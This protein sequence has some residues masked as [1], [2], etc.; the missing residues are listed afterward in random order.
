MR[1]EEGGTE[2]EGEVRER[3]GW[4]QGCLA[5]AADSSDGLAAQPGVVISN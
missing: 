3:R 5:S 1:A 2:G 4:G